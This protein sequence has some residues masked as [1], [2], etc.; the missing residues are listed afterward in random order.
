MKHII[1]VASGKGGVGK[2]VLSANIGTSLARSGKTV[3]LIDLDLGGSN[4]HTFLGI[5]NSFPGIGS[6][7]YREEPSL[8]SVLIKTDIPK[9]FFIPG[10]SLLPGTAN[11]NY[12]TKL[13]LI[14]AIKKLNADYIILDLASGS[15]FNTIDFFLISLSGLIIT[16][17]E[18]TAVLNAYSFL[19]SALF[20]LLYRS[21]PPKSAER[22]KIINM[23]SKHI[24]GTN[25][26]LRNLT[27][28][29]SSGN[30]ESGRIVNS[31]I[32][33]F[34]PRLILNMN[35]S[36]RDAKVAEK[37]IDIVYKNLNINLN[38]IGTVAKSD[39]VPLSIIKRK[40]LC[41]SSPEDVFSRSIKVITDKL[42][43]I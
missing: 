40:P 24:E 22:I 13:K 17:P 10:D 11:L 38:L 25:I 14:K 31:V 42:I 6:I 29:L 19:K 12:F 4:L 23:L 2:T 9:L 26:S 18:A 27:E 15:S 7:I 36:D 43:L 41:I 5:K 34:A 33:N 30:A 35:K 16:V 32:K 21:F 28:V 39:A 20:R 3:I 37:L 8:E 1:P